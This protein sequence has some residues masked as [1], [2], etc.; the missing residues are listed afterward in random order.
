MRA[1]LR[2]GTG[3]SGV[4]VS[5][6]AFA[7]CASGC[8]NAGS[9]TGVMPCRPARWP[10]RQ[11]SLTATVTCHANCP[12]PLAA[13][14]PEAVPV[15]CFPAV[16]PLA[17][18]GAVPARR[19]GTTVM[20][21]CI[22]HPGSE[23]ANSQVWLTAPHGHEKTRRQSPGFCAGSSGCTCLQGFPGQTLPDFHGQARLVH[24]IK[25]QARRAARQQFFAQFRYHI[26]PERP[27]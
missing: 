2:W 23:S 6:V 9:R 12:V 1:V 21:P 11:G 25:M 16:M 14:R 20:R 15:T 4:L 10:D 27:D 24:G 8:T 5:G 19:P 13:M 7:C 22:C 17:I 3:S 26:Q 18:A